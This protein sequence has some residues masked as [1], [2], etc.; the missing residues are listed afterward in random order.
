M[1]LFCGS[2][3]DPFLA[4]AIYA[5]QI[6]KQQQAAIAY[7]ASNERRHFRGVLG[8][9][10][11]GD[12]FGLGNL[13]SFSE[14]LKLK[15]ILDKTEIAETRAG[16]KIATINVDLSEGN[17]DGDEDSAM[18]QF[19][20]AISRGKS[21]EISSANQAESQADPVQ[22]ILSQA[23]I[24]YTHDNKETLGSSRVES[25]LSA[26]AQAKGMDSKQSMQRAFKDNKDTQDDYQWHPTEIVRKRQFKTMAREY[27]EEI[28]AFAVRVENWTAEE[29][30]NFLDDFYNHRQHLRKKKKK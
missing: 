1:L 18:S 7:T 12:I 8:S 28:E 19:A 11:K 17:V 13:L 22:A 16:V 15:D 14:D 26:Q 23:G 10:E 24:S 27:G 29:R 9:S 3:T 25:E 6:Y 4:E 2:Q 30:R 20:N 21:A 5:R